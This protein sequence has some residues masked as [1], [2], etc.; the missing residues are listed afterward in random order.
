[1]T[2]AMAMAMAVLIQRTVVARR[3]GLVAVVR[4]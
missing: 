4:P 3:D 1:M 2:M